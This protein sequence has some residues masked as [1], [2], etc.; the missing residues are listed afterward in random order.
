ML[1]K[2]L[3]CGILLYVLMRLS[4]EK[5]ITFA[6]GKVIVKSKDGTVKEATGGNGIT[7]SAIEIAIELC[8]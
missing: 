7:L 5:E 6:P 4:T 1:E 8:S 2:Y 3:D